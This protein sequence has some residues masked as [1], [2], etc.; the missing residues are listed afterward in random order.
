MTDR[1]F[2]LFYWTRDAFNEERD[3]LIAGQAARIVG[4]S[5][6]IDMSD[7]LILTLTIKP[8][9]PFQDAGRR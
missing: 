6:D 4:L 2:D 1:D 5:T 7:A 3:I 8:L 9:K